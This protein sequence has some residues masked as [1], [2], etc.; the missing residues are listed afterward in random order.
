MMRRIFWAVLCF[1]LAAVGCDDPIL[2]DSVA[3]VYTL[4][5][6]DGSAPPVI[7]TDDASG[8]VEITGGSLSLKSNLGCTLTRSYRT[9]LGGTPTTSTETDPC[10]WSRG[11]TS[12]F[13]TIP[14]VGA[15]PGTWDEATETL[16]F[17]LGGH[18]LTFQR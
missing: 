14:E 4:S 1:S 11:G 12:V 5:A 3:G 7:L 16:A 2:A 9:T 15:V 8:K 13:L 6:V 17:T 18:V 10:N